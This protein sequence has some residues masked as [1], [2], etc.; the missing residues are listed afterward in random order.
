M[1]F[2]AIT[3]VILVVGIFGGVAATTVFQFSR[4]LNTC[5]ARDKPISG[6][7]RVRQPS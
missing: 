3:T 1:R 7:S 5:D 6:T 2:A 4:K